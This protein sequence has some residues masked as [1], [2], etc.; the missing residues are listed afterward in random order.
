MS[1]KKRRRGSGE[2]AIYQRPDGRWCAAVD[3]GV[4][5]GK[6]RRKYVY[7]KTR[8]EVADKLKTLHAKQQQ[9]ATLKSS[10]RK[11]LAA[12]I[13]WWLEQMV[14]PQGS[15]ATYILYEK[16]TRLY[17]LP[18]LGT[19]RLAALTS[20]QCQELWNTLAET[21]SPGTV[22]DCRKVLRAG[23]NVAVRF[24]EILRNPVAGT[25]TPPAPRYVPPPAEIADV[26]ALVA[27]ADA[28]PIGMLVRV[29]VETGMRSGELIALRRSD[30]DLERRRIT[31]ATK[32]ARGLKAADGPSKLERGPT[33]GRRA[34]TVAISAQLAARLVAHLA[35][36]DAAAAADDQWQEHGLVLPGAHGGPMEQ[37][38]VRYYFKKVLTAAGLAPMRV[39]DLRH[40]AA[41]LALAGGV[42]P[43]VVRER[44]GHSSYAITMDVYGHLLPEV[45]DGAAETLGKLLEGDEKKGETE[46]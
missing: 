3:L 42:S 40:W 13:A 34:R 25:T 38:S 39:H 23:L 29:A 44:L 35:A 21:L 27:A 36:L 16:L 41:S 22:N 43:A 24:G 33:K 12:F 26:R 37:T 45:E 15:P 8:K 1:P 6:R 31:V 5:N 19:T 10:D 46:G 17:V 30:L 7:G 11:T 14:K 20:Q 2:G 28:G 9:G 32:L 18:T 4:V